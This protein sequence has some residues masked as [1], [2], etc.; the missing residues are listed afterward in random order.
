M[1]MILP[2]AASAPDSSHSHGPPSPCA[3]S[4]TANPARDVLISLVEDVL[5][6]ELTLA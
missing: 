5:T 6:R 3:T 2:T 4:A 1:V